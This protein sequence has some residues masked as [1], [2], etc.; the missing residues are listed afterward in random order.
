MQGPHQVAQKSMTTT[1][2]ARSA[3]VTVRVL[4]GP[5][6]RVRRKSGAGLPIV[7][8]TAYFGAGPRR[9]AWSFRSSVGVNPSGATK[10]NERSAA[11]PRRDGAGRPAELLDRGRLAGR[12][13]ARQLG[14]VD[15]QLDG[16]EQLGRRVD[17][18]QQVRP[19]L[20]VDQQGGRSGI[21]AAGR[22]PA[23]SVPPIWSSKTSGSGP[24]EQ[25]EQ[26]EG[27]RGGRAAEEQ[28]RRSAPRGRCRCRSSRGPGPSCISSAADHGRERLAVADQPDGAGVEV[29]LVG[30]DEASAGAAGP[31]VAACRRASWRRRTGPRRS[32]TS[33]AL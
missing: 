7:S 20:E 28:R 32:R 23:W 9:R 1:L 2:P 21:A 8:C 24:R 27:R 5:S 15:L 25:V 12:R 10:A 4:P 6:S 30:P 19:L 13:A 16:R 3:L 33:D 22:R 26:H 14:R 17:A 11:T 31:R 29:E 18:E